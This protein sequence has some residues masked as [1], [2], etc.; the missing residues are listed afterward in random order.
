MLKVIQKY[1][2][3]VPRI[4]NKFCQQLRL[5]KESPGY[6]IIHLGRMYFTSIGLTAGSMSMTLDLEIEKIETENFT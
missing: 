5:F 3:L 4:I 2:R 6:A 1:S